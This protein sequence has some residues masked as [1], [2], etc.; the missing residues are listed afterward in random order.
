MF[1]KHYAYLLSPKHDLLL[2]NI[3]EV[4][5][6]DPFDSTHFENKQIDNLLNYNYHNSVY[7][8]KSALLSLL[9]RIT[10]NHFKNHDTIYFNSD[11]SFSTKYL[12]TKFIF[13]IKKEF[14]F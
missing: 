4:N 8:T 10:I 14:L 12:K 5:L 9:S 7:I 1:L 3:P 13:E 11:F 6:N 2:S